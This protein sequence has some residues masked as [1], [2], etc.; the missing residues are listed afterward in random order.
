MTPVG[1]MSGPGARVNA[2]R[3]DQRHF[4]NLTHNEYRQQALIPLQD[5]T[6]GGEDVGIYAIGPLSHLF[7]KTV[8]NTFIA[9]AMKHALCLPPYHTDRPRCRP[10]PSMH[11]RPIKF[12]QSGAPWTTF[13]LLLIFVTVV[14]E[15]F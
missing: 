8:D 14:K 13:S 3:A 7:H 10:F 2:P 15:V 11:R 9:H 6:H 12:S 5:A 1:Y 4:H